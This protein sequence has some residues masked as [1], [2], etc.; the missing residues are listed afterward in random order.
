MPADH[1]RA[2]EL[3]LV[4]QLRD[5]RS[6]QV[7]F[8]SHCLLN[9]NTRYLGGACRAGCIPEVVQQC[10]DRDLGIV[11]LPCPEQLAWG[12]VLKRRLLF[13]YGLK[14][15]HPLLYRM[16]RVLLPIALLYT[17]LVYRRLA[18]ETARQVAD[19]LDSG[20]TVVGF[21]GVDGSPSCGVATTLDTS[22]LDGFLSLCRDTLTT[23]QLNNLV[24]ERA[25]PG[26]GLFVAELRKALARRRA[27]VP[28]LAHDLLAELDG[29]LS[30]V[31]LT[32]APGV[33]PSG[34][35]SLDA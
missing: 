7:V 19:Y 11:Q 31:Q 2:S 17:R 9:E 22:H 15:R 18:Q 8:L 20:F 13:T 16:R 6:Q 1:L 27:V 32:G 33:S 25:A 34:G 24:R 35:R 30:N 23:M 10:L 14:E 21:V 12:G 26:S 4:Q 3:A 5:R 28:F 29:R